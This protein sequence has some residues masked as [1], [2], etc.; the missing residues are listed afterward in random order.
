MDVLVLDLTHGGDIL[1][2]RLIARGD[3]VTVVDIYNLATEEQLES[4]RSEGIEACR[5]VPARTFD[6]LTAPSHCPDSLIGDAKF[7]ER[8]TFHEIVGEII[9]TTPFR[10]E[11]T[12]VKGKTSTCYLL[13]RLL[14]LQGDKVFLQTSRGR[15]VWQGGSVSEVLEKV[16]IAPT[17]LLTLPHDGY[18]RIIAEVSLGGS[19]KADIALITNLV[20]D[21]PIAAGTRRARES[22]AT[23]FTDKG[24]N[25]IPSDEQDVWKGSV[26]EGFV[27]YGDKVVFKDPATLSDGA[28]LDL[29]Y[30][31]DA[32]IALSSS[33]I[34][35]ASKGAFEAALAVAET[36]D[37]GRECLIEAIE[38]F[39]GV[40]GRGEVERTENGFLIT[41]RNPGISHISIAHLL[42]TLSKF[43][44]VEDAAVIIVPATRKVCE[45]MDMDSIN[46]VVRSFGAKLYVLD[47]DTG[48]PPVDIL[49]KHDLT[50]LFQK[51]AYQ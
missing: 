38:G 12:G 15:E 49:R 36:L 43:V 35:Q 42:S 1:A 34:P 39:K 31:G 3:V 22:K 32:N 40:P 9:G 48:Q 29:R 25:L 21:Y 50:L 45:K 10:I 17:S 46:D 23:V 11:V 41:E 20:D 13:A 24:I 16:S 37:I 5:T 8:M 28:S 6:L 14:S 30:G 2:R 18:D 33:Y 44:D 27:T 51:E 7:N 47:N 19:G 26:P 4:L